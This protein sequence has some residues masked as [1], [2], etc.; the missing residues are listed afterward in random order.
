ML[1]L[2]ENLLPGKINN[3]IYDYFTKSILLNAKSIVIIGATTNQNKDSYKVMKFL[4]EKGFKVIPI[5][6]QT[7]NKEI[8]GERIYADIN[9]I[10][11]DIVN[12]FRPSTE[13]SY[14]INKIIHKKVKTIWLKLKIFCN[15][16]EEK[17]SQLVINF[18]QKKCTKVEYEKLMNNDPLY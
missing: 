2:K 17:L 14:L 11:I 7:Q 6:S 15:E 12:I 10:D 16:Y 18:I 3:F 13:I 4:K 9:E 1:F 5:N 8:L